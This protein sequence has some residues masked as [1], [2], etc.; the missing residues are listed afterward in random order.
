MHQPVGMMA[1]PSASVFTAVEAY[2]QL[3]T[4][5]ERPPRDRAS[6]HARA[7]AVA[8]ALENARAQAPVET[9]EAFTGAAKALKGAAASAH[10]PWHPRWREL[11]SHYET[12]I[13]N[14]RRNGVSP[15]RGWTHLKPVNLKRNL[16]HTFN[17]VVSFAAYEFLFTRWQ[18]IG[19]GTTLLILF[20]AFDLLRR[21]RPN[22]NQSFLGWAA[23]LVRPSEA[24]GLATSTWYTAG[25][26][27]GTLVYPKLAIEAGCL[28]LAFAD[29]AATLAGKRWGRRKL[30]RDRSWVGSISFWVVGT[31]VT[32]AL[33]WWKQP[34]WTIPHLLGVAVA[35]GLAG[36][37]A[38]LASQRVDDNLTIPLLAGG[39]CALLL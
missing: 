27:L 23:W 18:M 13:D 17:G 29:P 5:H 26:T 24:H 36:A 9:Q 37:V 21:F 39:V 7:R 25:L 35:V 10:D 20:L 34:Q 15:P 19:I 30:W 16:F 1:S 33:L 4:N 3:V 12:L 11:A 14:L 31:V 8:E 22:L 38:E 28:V 32:A 2:Y 6:W